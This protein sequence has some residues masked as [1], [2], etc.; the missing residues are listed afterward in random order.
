MVQLA[1]VEREQVIRRR[2]KELTGKPKQGPWA[3]KRAPYCASV[4][5][6]D[7]HDNKVPQ[8]SKDLAAV[9]RGSFGTVA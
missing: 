9:G 3:L 5:V 2:Y 1:S 8:L 7:E 6:L 4:F